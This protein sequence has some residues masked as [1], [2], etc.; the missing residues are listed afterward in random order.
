MKLPSSNKTLLFIT[1]AAILL[2]SCSKSN[3]A[4]C[5]GA[6]GNVLNKEQAISVNPDI[7]RDS[8]SQVGGTCYAYAAWDLIDANLTRRSGKKSKNR[9][10][11]VGLL[12]QAILRSKRIDPLVFAEEMNRFSDEKTISKLLEEMVMD[13]IH[14]DSNDFV[15]TFGVVGTEDLEAIRRGEFFSSLEGGSPTSIL[16]G[17]LDGGVKLHHIPDSWVEADLAFPLNLQK[18]QDLL[19]SLEASVVNSSAPTI[20]KFGKKLDAD[21]YKLFKSRVLSALVLNMNGMVHSGGTL[22]EPRS[23]GLDTYSEVN[24]Y[25]QCTNLAFAEKVAPYLERD[26]PLGLTLDKPA[27]Y[28]YDNVNGTRSTVKIENHAVILTGI[29]VHENLDIEFQMRNSWNYPRNQISITVKP[30]DSNLMSVFFR[31]NAIHSASEI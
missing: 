6:S 21:Y 28:D 10:S 2:S 31:A 25:S 9:P 17:F 8:C 11:L 30:N 24:S 20:N 26:I 14:N 22:I 16:K 23:Y 27:Q 29:R 18:T 1:L 3:S 12:S 13:L 15:N 4:S 7:F 19:G 5:E